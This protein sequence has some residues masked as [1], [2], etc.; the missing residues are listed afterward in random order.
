MTFE[1]KTDFKGLTDYQTY[2]DIFDFNYI[3]KCDIP[4][5]FDGN[6]DMPPIPTSMSSIPTSIPSIPTSIPS[7]PTSMPSIPTISPIK[8]YIKRGFADNGNIVGISLGLIVSILLIFY[9]LYLTNEETRNES[10]T[11]KYLVLFL[12]LAFM[13]I[14]IVVFVFTF[15]RIEDANNAFN[16][17]IIDDSNTPSLRIENLN[18]QPDT[19]TK[20][21]INNNAA[22][23][24]DIYNVDKGY[25]VNPIPS[26]LCP[27]NLTNYQ[28][29]IGAMKALIAAPIIIIL[30][31]L[32]GVFKEDFFGFITSPF[33]KSSSI[34]LLIISMIGLI[35]SL[36]INI[37]SN[38]L[39]FY[40]ND[41]GSF[42][43]RIDAITMTDNR[44]M[45]NDENDLITKL[46]NFNIDEDSLVCNDNSKTLAPFSKTKEAFD[47]VLLFM[48]IILEIMLI[49][50]TVLLIT[51]SDLDT[52]IF[53]LGS[54]PA[55]K[56]GY[57][58]ITLFSGMTIFA[59]VI[60]PWT[61]STD[62]EKAVL[63]TALTST[64]IP[65]TLMI[66]TIIL[67]TL[68]GE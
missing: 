57:L 61:V 49:F 59:S 48:Y 5:E 28:N 3:N 56:I 52:S 20:L 13:T 19:L 68:I 17:N 26:R 46:K 23:C 7:I 6:L 44:I 29:N 24:K 51:Q 58:I 43:N 37:S 1:L 21:K 36:I 2:P 66:F 42:R 38:K 63:I 25:K 22:V 27:M 45:T 53:N 30:I 60:Y 55:S 10:D 40:C 33:V 32:F 41:L 65:L 4:E 64:L 12:T 18:I 9:G 54:E 15:K 39:A 31:V 67:T 11:S 34:L 14:L 62:R 50:F 47:G 16:C 35:A 8:P